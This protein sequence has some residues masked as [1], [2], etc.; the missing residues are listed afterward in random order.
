MLVRRRAARDAARGRRSRGT[1]AA[2][3]ARRA[4]AAAST[5]RRRSRR[6][7]VVSSVCSGLAKFH[8]IGQ[9]L[10]AVRQAGIG[11]GLQRRVVDA[12]RRCPRPPHCTLI[13]AAGAQRR[14]ERRKQRLVV[15]DPVEGR[16]GEHRVDLLAVCRRSVREVGLAHVGGASR[17]LGP[18]AGDHVRRRVD[19][20]DAPAREAVEQQPR[21]AARAAAGVEDRLV[22]AQLEAVD[23][24][25]GHRDLRAPRPGGRRRRSSRGSAGSQRGR[26]P[27]RRARARARRRRSRRPGRASARCR[28]GR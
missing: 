24:R 18:R 21:D 14:R 25:L 7:A 16:V 28:R 4:T 23:D 11:R 1:R 20:D 2:R 15:G 27:G 10:E 5:A 8:G 19:G 13:R 26:D 22:A 9:P 12:R 3:R 17:E 6:R